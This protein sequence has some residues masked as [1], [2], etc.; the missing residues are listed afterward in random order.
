MANLR[1][2]MY[3]I[4]RI[5]QLR[6][7]GYSK[8]AI[9]ATLAIA[10]NTVEHYLAIIEAHFADLEQALSW[11]D[12]Q[13]HRLFT[14]SVDPKA[15]RLGDL[16]QRFEG[17]E[18]QLSKPGVTRFHLW[19]TY[20]QANPN[21]VQ[22]T[23][24]CQRYKQWMRTQQTVMHLEH[25]AGDK[26]YVDF[27][28]KRLSL[29]DQSSG[30][31]KPVEFFVAILGCS[32]LTYAQAVASQNKEDFITAL[33]NALHFL[34][35]VPLAIVPDNLK[36]AVQTANRY[37]PDLNEAI[38][39]FA[40]HYG[41]CIYPA[42]SRR[43]RDKSLVEGAVNIL[44]TRV[45]VPLQERIFHSLESLNQ[46]IADLVEA[47][48][49]QLFQG[50]D[51]SRRQRFLSLEA[52]LLRPLPMSPYLIKGYRM[53][54]VL[55]NCHVLLQPDKHY[56]SVPH[57]FVSQAVK[58]IYTQQT[59]EIYHQ[60]QR[61]AT[62]T[63][64]R[65]AHGY[66]TNMDHLPSH[67]QWVSQWSPAFFREQGLGKGPYV[68]QAIEQ[69]LGRIEGSAGTYPQQI[70]RSCA[71]ILSLARK[72]DSARLEKACERALHYGTVSYKVIRRI[73]EAELDRLPLTEEVT[74]SIP[75]HDNIRGAAAYQ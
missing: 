63:R 45:Y 68:G 27:A 15:D 43:P 56:Y 20:K 26:L 23:Q 8:R 13:L 17:F 33:Q 70:Y 4:R 75:T 69:L 34:G 39:D 41:T 37:E 28:G 46:A 54:K 38:Q 72:V 53:A 3:Q 74:C 57:R 61:I 7:Q 36:A 29:V 58:L 73:L 67:Q 22:Y 6:Q 12:E 52:D 35:G 24:F 9:A 16:Y 31:E 64:V 32:Q 14:Y 30:E 18:Q 71:G 11:Q 66:S 2:P 5:L 51:Y 47:H 62:H 48:N 21:G 19:A 42:R 59:V 60:H 55:T 1:L 49:Q 65:L 25:K 40:A 50:K 44:Y 10:R